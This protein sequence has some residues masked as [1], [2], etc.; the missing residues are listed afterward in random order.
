MTISAIALSGKDFTVKSPDG[1]IS[2][3]LTIEERSMPKYNVHY[4]GIHL[5]EN[6][7]MGFIFDN[8]TFGQDVSAGKTEKKSIRGYAVGSILSVATELSKM[9][10]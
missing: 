9:C 7:K 2:F 8:G 10:E 4:D 6:G 1:R 5:I 3:T